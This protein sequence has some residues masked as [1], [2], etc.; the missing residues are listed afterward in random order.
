[1]TTPE[2]SP[3]APSHAV[4]PMASSMPSD[5]RW[6]VRLLWLGL[7]V[8]VIQ[9]LLFVP[10]LLGT[11][12]ADQSAHGTDMFALVL[13]VLWLIFGG[14][15]NFS[16][17]R[18]RNWARVLKL[19][20]AIAAVAMQTAFVQMSTNLE[21]LGVYVVPA[22]NFAALCLLFLSPGRLWFRQPSLNA[23]V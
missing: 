23:D 10:T 19:L 13:P 21:D 8:S 20:I 1:M 4:G 3:N 14:Y 17:S 5:I 6:A 12:P 16:I 15:L 11:M 7:A 22:I 9:Y 2:Y 18:R